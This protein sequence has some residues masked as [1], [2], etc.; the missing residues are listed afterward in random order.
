MKLVSAA[1]ASFLSA[2][3][4]LHDANALVAASESAAAKMMVFMAFPQCRVMRR[5]VA[6][7]ASQ[8]SFYQFQWQKSDGSTL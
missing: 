3:S 1:P 5:A 4:D 6:P 7:R 2:A 8:P